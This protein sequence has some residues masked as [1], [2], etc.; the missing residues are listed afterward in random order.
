MSLYK[1]LNKYFKPPSV[2]F[3]F[4]QN[5]YIVLLQAELVYNSYKKL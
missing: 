5:I 3:M 4:G 1:V 2:W